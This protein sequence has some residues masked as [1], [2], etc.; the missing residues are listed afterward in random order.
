MCGGLLAAAAL[1]LGLGCAPGAR[2][3]EAY[4]VLVFGSQQVPNN[5]D[6]SHSF[7]TFVRTTWPGDTAC[8]QAPPRLEAH[9]I[10]WLPRTLEVRSLALLPECGHNFDL[11]E[12]FRYALAND[13]RVSLWGP[14]QIE[15]ELYALALNQIAL[16]ESGEVLYKAN[17]IGRRSDRVSNC[18]NAVGSV[19]DGHG[20]R[21]PRPVWGET[22]SYAVLRRYL[23]W[24]IDPDRVH[25][26]VGAALGLNAY[27]I[28]YRDRESPHSGAF[29][30]PLYRLAGGER[31]LH[32]THGPPAD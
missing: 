9:T 3:G 26:W 13:E 23:P 11:H 17:D 28:I 27:P 7:A 22:A 31:D 19:V 1:T 14:Y 2:A 10:S 32:A 15:P 5:P 4:Y 6:Y 8:P 25:P 18:I 29:L 24:V 30:G 20:L 12:T 16:L 21:V